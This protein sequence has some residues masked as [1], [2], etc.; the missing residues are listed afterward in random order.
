ME[1]ELIDDVEAKIAS[2]FSDPTWIYLNSIRK[3]NLLSREEEIELAKKLEE[4]QKQI[5]DILF[6]SPSVIHAII[7]L[8]EQFEDTDVK[9]EDFI[10]IPGE[11]WTDV[12]VYK[13]EEKRVTLLLLKMIE[14][15]DLWQKTTRSY[16]L[17]LNK[18]DDE[19]KLEVIQQKIRDFY[20]TL[21][22]IAAELH[23]NQ[24]QTDRLIRIFKQEIEN[25]PLNLDL[26]KKLSYWENLR[27]DTKEELINANVRLVISIAKKYTCTNL[28][29]IDLV[30]EGNT[31]L[32]KAVE[33]FDYTKG[34]KFSTYA[35]WW[36][37]QAISRAIAEK[38]KTIRI[39]SNMLE[40]SRKVIRASRQF[41]QMNGYE[42]NIEELNKLTGLS[43]K[44]IKLAIFTSQEPVS[45]DLFSGDDQKN[46][47]SDFIEDKNTQSPIEATNMLFI[48]DLIDSIL[49]TLD[50]KEQAVLRMRFGLD[51]G[52]V[53]TLK[54][55]GELYDIS[56]ERVRQI[57]T[58]ALGKLKHPQRKKKLVDL[59]SRIE[60]LNLS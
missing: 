21:K 43:E 44:K 38:S 20:Q 24:K 32:I 46:K 17:A 29:L 42:P 30:Q 33:N 25:S 53:K 26:L 54:E 10:Q 16:S 14:Q 2:N 57:E 19:I 9:V 40:I 51:D 47:F 37:K 41:I 3:S 8:K 39:P 7:E 31:G 50:D 49:D 58:K 23:L 18:G 1:K 56:R 6:E 52:R 22:K 28:E 15:R 35:T 5:G 11:A 34:Y 55:T 60:D 4:I 13:N 45:L 36:I 12:Q 59:C 27:D 48:K